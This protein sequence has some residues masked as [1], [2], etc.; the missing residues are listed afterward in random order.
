MLR[1]SWPAGS[2]L[3]GDEAAGVVHLGAFAESGAAAGQ[4]LSSCLIFAE[5]CPWLPDLAAAR[6]W[7]LR[8]MATDPAHRGQGAGTALLAAAEQIAGADGATVLWCLAR[9]GAVDFYRR[10][11]WQPVGELF[12]TELG[13]HR[14]MWRELAPSTAAEDA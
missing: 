4:L 14:R 12:D 1:P 11:G 2:I 3:P 6:A 5:P 7:R 9:A 13:P 10:Q 8:G